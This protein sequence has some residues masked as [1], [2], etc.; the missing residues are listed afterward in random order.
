M[1]K[2]II[3]VFV[4]ILVCLAGLVF[5]EKRRTVIP[6]KGE[7]F[8]AI[9]L[10]IP[11]GW[12]TSND[13]KYSVLRINKGKYE[14][15]IAP[16]YGGY[17]CFFNNQEAAEVNGHLFELSNGAYE[18]STGSGDIT[19]KYGDYG[20]ANTSFGKYRVS[21]VSEER[22]DISFVFCKNKKYVNW[23][24]SITGGTLIGDIRITAPIGYDETVVKEA[25]GIVESIKLL[26]Q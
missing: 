19:T 16:M 11:K 25:L 26:K 5:L 2:I 9:S 8:N 1:K 24:S 13:E 12:E 10:V 6:H 4:F 22:A 21:W 7:G 17:N 18:D 20:I 15:L 3:G 14:L 23:R